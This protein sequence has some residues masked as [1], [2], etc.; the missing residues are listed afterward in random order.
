MLQ[1]Q[2]EVDSDSEMVDEVEQTS[3]KRSMTGRRKQTAGMDDENDQDY[4][5]GD[6]N[7]LFLAG[8]KY[9]PTDFEAEND[10]AAEFDESV[11]NNYDYFSH[12]E[13]TPGTANFPHNGNPLSMSG[14]GAIDNQRTSSPQSLMATS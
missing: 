12:K 7:E 3:R 5:E 13:S 6:P 1:T 14:N 2:Y 8:T 9:L 11:S 10:D 4:L